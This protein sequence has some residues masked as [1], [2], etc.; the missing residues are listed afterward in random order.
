M[1]E[2]I[3]KDKESLAFIELDAFT[4]G[5]IE[6]MFFTDTCHREESKWLKHLEDG[7]NEGS[8]PCDKGFE[9]IDPESLK[10][11]IADCATFIKDNNDLLGKAWS[12]GCGFLEGGYDESCAGRDFWFTRNGH[13][14]GYWDRGLDDIGEELTKACESYKEVMT[15]TENGLVYVE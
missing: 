13:G 12:R 7:T 4:Q 2:F 8:I 1:P 14:V 9:D 11:I 10:I 15:F 5:Y 6:A 3:I